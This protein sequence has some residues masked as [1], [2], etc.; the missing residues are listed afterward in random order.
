MALTVKRWSGQTGPSIKYCIGCY[1]L[2][3]DSVGWGPKVQ[4]RLG[5]LEEKT[6]ADGQI[7]A[8]T[9]RSVKKKTRK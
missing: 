2:R 3:L 5:K 9:V 8:E 7:Y 1:E 4:Q 6:A